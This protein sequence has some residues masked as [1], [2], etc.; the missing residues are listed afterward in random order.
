MI[1][2]GKERTL[3][4]F[5]W[6]SSQSPAAQRANTQA[7]LDSGEPIRLPVGESVTIDEPLVMAHKGGNLVGAGGDI[8]NM[9]TGPS[10][11]RTAVANMPLIRV[12]GENCYLAGFNLHADALGGAGIVVGDGIND[13]V[14][15]F[16]AERISTSFNLLHGIHV[17]NSGGFV[18]NKCWLW[19]SDSALRLENLVSSDTGDNKITN[20][21]FNALGSG[22]GIRWTSGGGLYVTG[23]KFGAGKNH[24]NIDWNRGG[25]G[26]FSLI[27]CSL[28]T[29]DHISVDMQGSHDFKRMQIVG[30]TWG[31]VI[32]AIAVRN[33][34][35]T[36]WLKELLI[37]GNTIDNNSGNPC[38][39]VGCTDNAFITG[40]NIRS[41]GGAVA[42]IML[43]NG[44]GA[45]GVNKIVGCA[46]PVVVAGG[47]W[48]VAAQM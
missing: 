46:S 39:D 19:G 12:L 3:D 13:H 40:N 36:N 25:S 27:G 35:P 8:T 43:R 34:S 1:A 9:A 11:I 31:G 20:C 23:C 17:K 10:Q 14:R 37:S 26:N 29:C 45:V 7:A 18:L 5:G 6:N 47:S 22:A 15:G 44:N 2:N 30:N 48:N 21:D 24:I 41:S 38:I 4:E 28:E 33:F 16:V 32:M 42:G